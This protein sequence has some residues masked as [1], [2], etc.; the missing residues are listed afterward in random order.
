MTN[1]TMNL[2]VFWGLIPPVTIAVWA[3]VIYIIYNMIKDWRR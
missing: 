3:L 1:E 2:I